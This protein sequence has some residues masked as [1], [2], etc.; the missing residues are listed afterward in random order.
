LKKNNNTQ[1]LHLDTAASQLTCPPLLCF[2]FPFSPLLA[3]VAENNQ[4]LLLH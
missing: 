2:S 4:S 1:R 3:P